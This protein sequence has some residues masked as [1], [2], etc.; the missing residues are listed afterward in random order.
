MRKSRLAN[1]EARPP[2][3]GI[4]AN[5]AAS[6]VTPVLA[7]NYLRLSRRGLNQ[8]RLA[9]L[10]ISTLHHCRYLS[11]DVRAPW[12]HEVALLDGMREFS[13]PILLI[14]GFQRDNCK[15]RSRLSIFP[16]TILQFGSLF[17]KAARQSKASERSAQEVCGPQRGQGPANRGDNCKH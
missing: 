15:H 4:T 17:R 12:S 6:R 8:R 16:N 10:L 1:P 7:C 3:S 2:Q 9:C 13:Q 14:A 5:K 11:R